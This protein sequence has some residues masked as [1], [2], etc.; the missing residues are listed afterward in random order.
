MLFRYI[1]LFSGARAFLSK[2][3]GILC[4]VEVYV[5][6]DPISGETLVDSVRHVCFCSAIAFRKA[7]ILP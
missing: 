2:P 1:P 6:M 7:L 4:E 3:T 5:S